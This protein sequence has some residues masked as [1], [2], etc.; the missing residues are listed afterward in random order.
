MEPK[1]TMFN[2]ILIAVDS[3]KE[4]EDFL[5]YVTTLFP[6]AFYYLAT[7]I[8]SSKFIGRASHLYEEYVSELAQNTMARNE[9]VLQKKG[10]N[11]DTRIEM[12]RVS[13]KIFEI[14]ES[15]KIDLLVVGSH[16]AAGTT[17]FKLG[18]IAKD[19][20]IDSNI[21]ILIMN[22]LVSAPM[23]PRI[24]NPTT[25]SPYSYRASM[26]AV[27]LAKE[28]NGSMTCLH[29]LKDE[30]WKRYLNSVKNKAEEK[31]VLF[32]CK[33]VEG[34]PLEAILEELKEHDIIVGSRGYKGFKYSLRHIFKEFALDSLVRDSISLGKK[35]VLLI[36][37]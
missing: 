33:K 31:G 9:K 29:I 8:D 3:S 16:S 7:V 21:P 37:D 23:Y 20:L 14:V 18:G 4:W 2:R 30:G 15:E 27:E 5:N 17:R 32:N 6:D 34:T 11:Y 35:P 22:Y 25:G 26:L 28:L 36:C 10:V 13:T 24:L 19:I 12:G 1:K